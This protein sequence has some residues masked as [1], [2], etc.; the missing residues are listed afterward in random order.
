MITK[1][2]IKNNL[3]KKITKYLYN[4]FTKN[5]N[6]IIIR[7]ARGSQNIY[8]KPSDYNLAKINTDNIIKK[9]DTI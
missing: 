2:N 6:I 1:R 7:K 4:K 3:N 9:Q 5:A 8:N